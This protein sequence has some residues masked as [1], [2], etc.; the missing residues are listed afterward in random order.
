MFPLKHNSS[1]AIVR[2]RHHIFIALRKRWLLV[3][4][5]GFIGVTIVYHF[6]GW[7]L[8]SAVTNHNPLASTIANSDS[9]SRVI[10]FTD[11]LDVTRNLF[12]GTYIHLSLWLYQDHGK[13]KSP[14]P[15][16]LEKNSQCNSHVCIRR[17][18][19]VRRIT[20]SSSMD[21]LDSPFCLTHS[22]RLIGR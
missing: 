2:H 20:W 21:H 8:R 3:C 6:R 12:Y 4:L 10:D 22:Q 7:E 17:K 1:P 15:S 9:I 13:P 16:S 19:C 11:P 18:V 5:L 14:A